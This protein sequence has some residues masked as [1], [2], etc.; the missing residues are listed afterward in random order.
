MLLFNTYLIQDNNFRITFVT[1]L[2]H[3]AT[4]FFFI[5]YHLIMTHM[6]RLYV[7]EEN[8]Y[9]QDFRKHLGF[10]QKRKKILTIGTC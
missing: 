7:Q 2:T 10:S 4:K 1:Y 9:E 6:Q 3:F 5:G 8:R